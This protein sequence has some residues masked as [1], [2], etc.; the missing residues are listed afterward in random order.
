MLW[1]KTPSPSMNGK[2]HFPVNGLFIDEQIEGP[3]AKWYTGMSSR[4]AVLPPV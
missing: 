3:S 1:A 2:M 4:L